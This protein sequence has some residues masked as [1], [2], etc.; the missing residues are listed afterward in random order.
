MLKNNKTILIYL[1]MVVISSLIQSVATT[2]FSVPGGLY[3]SGIMGISRL[4]S[5]VLS[6]FLS[7]NITYNVFYFVTN[8][9]LGIVVFKYIGKWFT[10]L[11]VIQTTLVSFFS[12]FI[13]PIF[14]LNELI[15]VALF[16]GVINGIG[17]GIAL[18]NN[19]STGGMDF[20]TI[21]FSNKYKKSVWNYIFALNCLIVCLA[22]LIYGWERA[23][24]SIIYQ[25]AS[26]TMVKKMH[27]R[28]THQTLTIITKNPDEVSKAILEQVR[29]GITR[30]EGKGVYAN[31]DETMLYT[32]INSFQTQ[33]V[34][35][36]ALKGD[37]HCFINVQDTKEIKGNFFQK[38]LD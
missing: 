21:Y 34:I 11:S 8:I 29:H 16:G 15:L 24:Y 37:P 2:S 38:P 9:I 4:L 5:D 19:A 18:S 6:D 23:C 12:S 17:C 13:P 26:T 25:F 28:Y 32:V 10:I 3:P 30:F 7:I 14:N 20:I 33:Q 22:G 1:G 31:S 36:A 35:N 27:K